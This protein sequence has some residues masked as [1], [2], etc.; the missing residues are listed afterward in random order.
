MPFFAQTPHPCATF[1]HFSALSPTAF[2]TAFLSFS[3][4]TPPAKQRFS[5]FHYFSILISRNRSNFAQQYKC[6]ISINIK[7][8]IWKLS[9]LVKTSNLLTMYTK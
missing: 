7:Y 8:I 9:N 1:S 3:L 6:I 4:N 5:I 2:M